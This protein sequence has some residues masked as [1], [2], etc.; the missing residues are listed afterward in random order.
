VVNPPLQQSTSQPSAFRAL[1]KGTALYSVALFGQRLA[2]IFLL[3]PFNSR[4]L[5]KS[6]FGV[7]EL[8][9]QVMMVV[10]ILLAS[11]IAAL[12]YFYFEK[13]DQ[14]ARDGVAATTMIGS[15]ILGGAAGLVGLL[16]VNP[17]IRLV[18]GEKADM[19]L[20]LAIC[21]VCMGFSFVVEAVLG[22]VRI[23]DRPVI[24][25]V[26]TLIRTGVVVFATLLLVAWFRLGVLGVIISSN[27]AIVCTAIFLSIYFF[28]RVRVSFDRRLFFRMM[29]FALPMIAGSIAMFVLHFGDRFILPHYRTFSELGVYGVAY[30]I[31]MVISFAYGSFHVYWA[32]KVFEFVRRDDANIFVPRVATY[33]IVAL[34]FGTLALIVFC[35]PVV[36]ILTTSKFEE[37]AYLAPI[38]I[39]AYYVRSIAEFFRC[40]FLVEGKPGYES[41]CSWIGAVT[42]LA[43]Y[44]LLIPPYGMWGAAIATAIAF[45]V[46]AA[47]SIV[48]ST[49][50]RHYAWETRRIFK[51]VL[52]LTVLVAFHLY[53]PALPVT[54]EIVRGSVF[55]AAFPI[56][57]WVLRV[58]LAG[59]IKQLQLMSLGL[60]RRLRML[61]NG[62]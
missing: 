20:A 51:V 59:E 57:I 18:F 43:A 14:K 22:W 8:I 35:R 42:C 11:Q 15:G 60:I 21:F 39:C 12:G 37:A 28:R 32:A 61:P 6:D 24:Y 31:G 58:P 38:L 54:W 49:R 48:W 29:R 19:G 56:L 53:L 33:L 44:F 23:V 50:L 46:M 30:K 3:L 55:V 52:I 2:T 62:A 7:L 47:V 13:D 10:S 27:L 26:A 36:Y 9:E 4:L 16:F 17:I 45:A 40:F 1:L 5:S 25:G 41:A 34:S